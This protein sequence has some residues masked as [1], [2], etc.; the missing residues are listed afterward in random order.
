MKLPLR[1]IAQMTGAAIPEDESLQA[2][3]AEGYSI[4]SRTV[5]PG[6]IFFAVRGPNFDGHD[7]IEAALARGA[8]AAVASRAPHRLR[9]RVLLVPN[10]RLALQQ[11]AARARQRWGGRIVA[12][13]GSNGKTTTKEVTAALL[14]TRF[15]VAKSEGN[16]N[17]DLGVPLSLLRIPD[18]SEVG[19]LELG[20]NHAGEIRSLAA[21]AGP[22]VGVVTNVN[23]VHLEFFDSVDGIALAK[24]ELIEA[25]PRDG[26]A[27]L[28]ADDSR[29]LG[30]AQIFQGRVLTF[31]IDQIADIRALDVRDQ[32]LQGS[33]FR[34]EQNGPEFLTPLP[35][36]HNLYNTL[37]GIAAAQA[38]DVP[39][40]SLRDAV[41]K[42]SAV[43]MRGEILEIGE[44]RVIDDCYNS[45]PRAAEAMLDLLAAIPAQR[46]VAVL[47]Q[48]LELGTDGPQLHR[49]VGRKAAQA[50]VDLL[51]GVGGAARQLVDQAIDDGMPE[52]A[53]RFF[54]DAQ[55][56]G[57]FLQLAV[58]PGDLIL[59]KGSRGVK[60]ERA[61]EAVRN[62]FSAMSK[63]AALGGS[64][65]PKG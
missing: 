53:A 30:F 42:L 19:V 24:R 13:T 20:M 3:V 38:L 59:F 27:V 32:G 17:N 62:R 45:N 28:N 41:R 33:R 29:V 56:A 55:T 5:A 23:A 39:A 31:G 2:A 4:D 6:E 21:I 58:R 35:G 44:I 47:G 12:I 60:L 48:M 57:E 49:Q 46:H 52:S 43:R 40:G 54:A 26:T 37:A 7:F 14:S 22:D 64:L 50:G 25:L 34:L 1:E 16:L 18:Q 8:V 61:L 36:R 15:R 9:E 65:M 11:L 10:P 63:E 51:V